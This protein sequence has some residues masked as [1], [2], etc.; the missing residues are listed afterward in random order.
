MAQQG[1]EPG[2]VSPVSRVITTPRHWCPKQLGF[3]FRPACISLIQSDSCAIEATTKWSHVLDE[4]VKSTLPFAYFD[5]V[6]QSL[7][8][9][10]RR[11]GTREDHPSCLR[12]QHLPWGFTTALS[13]TPRYE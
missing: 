6:L 5:I 4:H 7:R 11:V 9:Q 3:S 12:T 8:M 2:R 1:F 13:H 10:I